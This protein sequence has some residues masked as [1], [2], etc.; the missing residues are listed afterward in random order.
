MPTSGQGLDFTS[1]LKNITSNDSLLEY[2]A[3][4]LILSQ[5]ERKVHPSIAARCSWRYSFCFPVSPHDPR[6]Q[7]TDA[8]SLHST[9]LQ[10]EQDT[11]CVGRICRNSDHNPTT[12]KTA[13]LAP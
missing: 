3:E 1:H 13:I 10:G 2:H 6:A 9:G 11:A 12:L 7:G 8:Y 5:S 4:A